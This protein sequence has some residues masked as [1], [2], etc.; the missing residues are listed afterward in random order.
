M[1]NVS[2]LLIMMFLQYFTQGAWNMTIG[3]VLADYGMKNS[4]GSTYA[5]LGLATLISPLFIGMIA[6]R[7]LAAQ[8]TIAILHLLNSVILYQIPS[9]ILH[10]E[11]S[12][13]FMLIFIV[14]LLYYPTTAL[15]NSITFQHLSDSR[16]FPFIR[17]FG[18]IG[19]ITAG[20]IM[21]YF[22]IF[23]QVIVF[24]IAAFSSLI[25]GLYCF[26]LP[27][28]PPA[29]RH[30]VINWKTLLCLDAFILFRDKFF[31]IFMAVTMLLML[32]KTSYS[33][34]ISVYLQDFQLNAA[35]MMQIAVIS[36]VIFMLLLSLSI[37]KFG[38]KWVMGMALLLGL[39]ALIYC[40]L[41][42]LLQHR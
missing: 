25:C 36:E 4:I 15:S 18:N 22:N 31:T 37:K 42:Q 16:N 30:S 6:D 41:P 28:T 3:A 32:T 34:Y 8:K 21:G 5:L 35:N 10:N 24:E 7:F 14:G 27:N 23:D 20:L 40:R 9:T 11:Y 17:I 2:R 33:A 29:A 19:F 38:F 12:Q 13:F 1:F 39:F 26:T